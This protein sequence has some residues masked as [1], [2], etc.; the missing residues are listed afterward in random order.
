MKLVSMLVSATT[1][2]DSDGHL[3][4]SDHFANGISTMRQMSTQQGQKVF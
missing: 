2:M 3:G 4:F 1:A